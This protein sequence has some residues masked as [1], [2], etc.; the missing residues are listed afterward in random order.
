MDGKLFV[1]YA[2]ADMYVG[3]ATCKVDGLIDY[4]LSCPVNESE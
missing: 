1:Y 4:L 3:L 2:G